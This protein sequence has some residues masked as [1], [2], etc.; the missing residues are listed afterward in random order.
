MIDNCNVSDIRIPTFGM[1][2]PLLSFRHYKQHKALHMEMEFAYDVKW[3]TLPTVSG[4]HVN[5]A[6]AI[7]RE[8]NHG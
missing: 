7:K 4:A 6:D 5:R 1:S 2:Y 8:I 3:A